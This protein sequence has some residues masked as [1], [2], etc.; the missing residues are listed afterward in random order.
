MDGYSRYA[1]Y[2]APEGA[3]W[4]AASA[5]LG[6]DSL[7]GSTLPHPALPGLP[8]LPAPLDEITATP[9]KY[10]FHGTIKPPFRLAPGATAAALATATGAHCAGLAR[11]ILPGLALHRLGGFL[12]LTPEGDQTAL[13]A[14]AARV[15]EGLDAFRAPPDASEITR[16]RPE[17]LTPGQRA[18][19]DRWGYPYVMEEFRFHLTLSGDLPGDMA[20]GVARVLAPWIAPHLPRPF[21]VDSL[22]L[23]G[24]GADGRF[25]IIR[26]YPL[27]G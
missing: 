6:W 12:A 25:R 1:I 19:L 5:W 7:S 24:E 11:V 20:D 17:R 2:A 13:A 9:R 21:V 27:G 14:L 3:L 23:C 4:E 8:G 18:N 26:R 16:R 10:G 22:C 15:V